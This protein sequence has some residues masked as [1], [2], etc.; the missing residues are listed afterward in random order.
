MVAL[1][2]ICAAEGV[3]AEPEAL[4]L[5]AR[6]AEARCATLFRARP[7]IA[8][9]ERA[10]RRRHPIC[11]AFGQRRSHRTLRRIMR[12]DRRPPETTCAHQAGAEPADI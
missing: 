4:A 5:I 1:S 6:V 11:W 12:A 7:G 8:W 3:T 9:G 10:S 2:K